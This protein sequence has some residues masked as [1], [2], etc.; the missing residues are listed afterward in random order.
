MF[1]KMFVIQRLFDICKIAYNFETKKIVKCCAS[2]LY[3]ILEKILL[4][5]Q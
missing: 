5:D 4:L 1:R 3:V 2:N